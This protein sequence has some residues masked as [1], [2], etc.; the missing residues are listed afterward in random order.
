MRHVHTAGLSFVF[1]F[2]QARKSPVRGG[3][4][5]WSPF[6]PGPKRLLCSQAI[7]DLEVPTLAANSATCFFYDVYDSWGDL[8][9]F[10]L[11]NMLGNL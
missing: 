2:I 7:T 3:V 9:G 1:F 8:K 10:A 11:T 4:G 5:S 6:K